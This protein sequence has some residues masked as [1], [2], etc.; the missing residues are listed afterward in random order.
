M[1]IISVVAFNSIQRIIARNGTIFARYWATNERNKNK[2]RKLVR[3]TANEWAQFHR[4]FY[5]LLLFFFSISKLNAACLTSIWSQFLCFAF[6]S[7]GPFESSTISVQ[8]EWICNIFN[9]H[10]TKTECFYYVQ[11]SFVGI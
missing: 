7:P 3:L 4:V 1:P 11:F 8:S 9:G 2:N 6:F 10:S 5:F